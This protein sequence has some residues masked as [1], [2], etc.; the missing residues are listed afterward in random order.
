MSDARGTQA[1]IAERWAAPAVA[2]A[3]IDQCRP[4]LRVTRA[5]HSIRRMSPVSTSRRAVL[6]LAGFA[7]LGPRLARG[8]GEDPRSSAAEANEAAF[9]EVWETVRDRFYDPHLHGLD[10]NAMR[11]RYRPPAI[12]AGR[13][14]RT[15]G[16]VNAMLAE[17]GAS[18]THYF[19]PDDPA[20]YQLAD[21]FAGALRRRGSAR[22]FPS[23]RGELS[24]HRHL[25]RR[26]GEGRTFVSGVIDGRARARPACSRR[27]DP[28]GGRRAV[29]AGRLVPRQG[30]QA[31]VACTSAARRGAD[32]ARSPSPRADS[33]RTTRFLDGTARRAPASSRRRRRRIGYIHVW[34]YAGRALSG[35]ARE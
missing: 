27:R 13:P 32:A 24:R 33:I 8:Q 21:I 1:C 10:W 15:R 29:P 31:S 35:G 4:A 22:I 20:Y 6:G 14:G 11:E 25:H 17:L 9:D 28:D 7:I 16:H 12:E 2:A 5:R 18:H 23:R 34:S 26:D 30:R 3:C 19:T